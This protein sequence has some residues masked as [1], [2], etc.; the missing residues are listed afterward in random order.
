MLDPS[1]EAVLP[2]GAVVTDVVPRGGGRSTV[3][4]VRLASG[5]PV[6]VKR[7]PDQWR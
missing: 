7:Y 3:H 6:I 5:N 2:D 1:L 4:E